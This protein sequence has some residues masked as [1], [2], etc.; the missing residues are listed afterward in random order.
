[1]IKSRGDTNQ[2]VTKI[3]HSNDKQLIMDLNQNQMW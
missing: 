1:M 2:Q 3:K